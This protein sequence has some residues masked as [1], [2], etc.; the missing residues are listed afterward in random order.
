[1]P[2]PYAEK[3]KV[4]F[5]SLEGVVGL[6]VYCKSAYIKVSS[7]SKP[8]LTDNYSGCPFYPRKHDVA[9]ANRRPDVLEGL[10]IANDLNAKL[11]DVAFLAEIALEGEVVD[12]ISLKDASKINF[13]E[14]I[15]RHID[16]DYVYAYMI[17]RS[18][19]WRFRLLVNVKNRIVGLLLEE[20]GRIFEGEEAI[21]EL[22]KKS[23]GATLTI[24]KKYEVRKP[25]VVK[26]RLKAE[27]L[28]VQNRS[29]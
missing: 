24:I 23:E 25:E 7:R 1:M 2:C 6:D 21:D 10:A 19:D 12:I 18:G 9:P 17:P 8:C 20:N 29:S 22:L 26:E 5:A 14:I 28:K 13:V 16:G 15:N 27:E 4:S 3:I 11:K